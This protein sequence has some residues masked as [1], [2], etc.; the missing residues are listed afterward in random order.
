MK[1][2]EIIREKRKEQS[3]TQ[4][5]VA[6]FLG[7]STPAVNKWEKG[8]TYPDI[9]I[10]PALARLLKV[11]LNTLLSFNEDLSEIEVVN[12]INEISTIMQKDGFY[13]GFTR[14]IEMIQTYPRSESLIIS[15]AM[16]LQGGLSIFSVQD[17][18]E[19]E[20]E[21]EKLYLRAS[22]SDNFE[23]K[24]KA[25]SML[26]SK[27]IERGDFDKAQGVINTLPNTFVDKNQIQASLYMKEEKFEEALNL[28]EG[29]LI[30][31]ATEVQ[32]ILLCMLDIAHKENRNDDAIYYAEISEKTVNLYDLWNYNS[33]VA[34]F[35]LA[36]SEK[37][38]DKCIEILNLML[39]AM[40]NSNSIGNSKL[41]RHLN[42]KNMNESFSDMMINGFI[43]ELEND[44]KLSFLNTNPEVIKVLDKYRKS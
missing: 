44:S 32:S 25:N 16:T 2:N 30:Q 43:S 28:L 35:Q 12:F 14:A 39:P 33:Y 18:S 34:K 3:L 21:I 10:L 11:D 36:V 20:T 6:E 29:K 8:I 15:T 24:N 1:I 4:E 23:I 9:T 5:Q 38:V 41:Y 42:M 37:N 40:K 22:L 31:T 19:Y 13:K 27:Y 26:I 17:K 7:V